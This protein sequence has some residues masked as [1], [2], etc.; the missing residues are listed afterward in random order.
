M[1]GECSAVEQESSSRFTGAHCP[2]SVANVVKKLEPCLHKRMVNP[3]KHL[4]SHAGCEDKVP[5]GTSLKQSAPPALIRQCTQSTRPRTGQD[6]SLERRYGKPG[7]Y[8][9]CVCE[10]RSLHRKGCCVAVCQCTP[11]AVSAESGG[12]V[13]MGL[14][15]AMNMVATQE[16]AALQAHPSHCMTDPSAIPADAGG[17]LDAPPGAQWVLWVYVL[18]H[19]SIPSEL[20]REA[21]AE[22]IVHVQSYRN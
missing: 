12:R 21:S 20:A 14:R 19:G 11:R 10:D 8:V 6:R 9:Y 5:L 22:N 13:S 16:S 18:R 4:G 17:W 3:Q 7:V 15:Q 2:A 1:T